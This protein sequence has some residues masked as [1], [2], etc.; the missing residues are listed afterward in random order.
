M[1]RLLFIEDG[2][3]LQRALGAELR[4][5]G[6]EVSGA[7]GGRE[8]LALARQR[9]P[10]LVVL[11][12]ELPDVPGTEVCRTLR[13]E[14]PTRDVPILVVSERGDEID[15][16]VAF[17]L[18]ADDFVAKPFS[19]REL[20]LRVQAVLRRRRAAA[21]PAGTLELGPLR[22][23]RAAHRVWIDG[24]ELRLT[25]LEFKLLATLAERR[26]RVQ[27]RAALLADVWELTGAVTTRTVDTHVKRLRRRLGPLA[28]C[29]ETVR[30]V[31]YRFSPA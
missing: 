9:L 11:D 7:R 25:P 4:Q 2:P 6:H 24:R 16:V 10:D 26:D 15:R 1:A 28:I 17:E 21:S 20:A 23:D 30:G 29:I 8:G 27:S 14:Q 18:G 31:G 13:F 3:E 12:L 22:L 19:A 5:A